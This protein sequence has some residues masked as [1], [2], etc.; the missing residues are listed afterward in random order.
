MKT[1]A[2]LGRGIGWGV[3]VAA[4]VAA[5]SFVMAPNA[6][7]DITSVDVEGLGDGDAVVGQLYYLTATIDAED[8]LGNKPEVTFLNGSKCLGT[9][10]LS[11]ASQQARL[12]WVPTKAG[13]ASIFAKQGLDKDWVTITVVDAPAGSKPAPQPS[14]PGCAA[15]EGSVDTGSAGSS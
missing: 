15:G 4:T 3:Q 2:R 9:V 13:R 6:S 8:G 12:A 11:S 14:N 10:T 5:V 1:S 7:A